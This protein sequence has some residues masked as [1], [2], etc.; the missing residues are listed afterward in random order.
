M[1]P[2]SKSRSSSSSSSSSHKSSKSKS[3]R[4]TLNIKR[5]ASSIQKRITEL[6]SE[7]DNI[8]QE[9]VRLGTERD[10][11]NKARHQMFRTAIKQK[12]QMIRNLI[13]TNKHI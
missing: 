5:Y 9:L 12:L 13:T 11:F 7:I 8:K 3:I 6:C 1:I 10:S 2:K 4:K